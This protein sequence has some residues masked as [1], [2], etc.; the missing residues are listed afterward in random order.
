MYPVWKFAENAVLFRLLF[1]VFL[2]F[3]REIGRFPFHKNLSAI[4]EPFPYPG[5]PEKKGNR[6][7]LSNDNR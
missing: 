4:A 5:S 2:H 6:T 7:W 3:C 1:S